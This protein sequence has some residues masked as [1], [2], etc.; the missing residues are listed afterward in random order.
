MRNFAIVATC[1]FVLPLAI[2]A[3]ALG[4]TTVIIRNTGREALQIGFDGAV[5]QTIAPRATA[6]LSLNA[7]PHTVQCRF[8][9]QFDGCNIDQ[10]FT[11]AETQRISLDIQPIYTLQHAVTLAQQGGLRVE[12]RRDMVWATRA[13]DVAGTGTDC[14]SYESG[15]LGS[16]S[17]R[18]SSGMTVAEVALA[19]QQLC[20]EARPVVSTT[21]GGEKMYVQPNFLIFRDM[22]GHPVLVRQ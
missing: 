14:A 2:A 19:T 3:P 12:T 5:A 17:S 4:A 7:G 15:K 11:L 8:E 6:S 20:G 1:A 16:V 10:Q 13:Q 9:G 18:I 22:T 21:I